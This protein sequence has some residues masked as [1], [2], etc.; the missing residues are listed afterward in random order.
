MEL[1]IAA[2]SS[3]LVGMRQRYGWLVLAVA[4]L[5]TLAVG[6]RAETTPP[7]SSPTP[8]RHS[9]FARGRA[10]LRRAFLRGWHWHPPP[11]LPEPWPD[12]S[13]S[14]SITYHLAPPPQPP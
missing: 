12:P 9:V 7:P 2:W 3:K 8:R 4:T 5:W 13:P 10:Q 14:L 1:A 6:T 11:L